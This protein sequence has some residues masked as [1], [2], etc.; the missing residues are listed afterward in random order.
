MLFEF[1]LKRKVICSIVF[2]NKIINQRQLYLT[3]KLHLPKRSKNP[4]IMIVVQI[5]H[6]DGSTFPVNCSSPTFAIMMILKQQMKNDI[7]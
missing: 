6:V 2:V 4:K 7:E 3:K 5:N 1:R